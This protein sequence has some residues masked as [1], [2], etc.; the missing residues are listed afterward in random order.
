MIVL[1]CTAKLLD[2]LRCG[3]T[4][5]SAGSTTVLG[6]WYA[7]FVPTRPAQMVLLVS[8]PSRLPV[9]LPAREFSTLTTRIPDAVAGILEGLGMQRDMVERER[10][11]MRHIVVAPTARRSVLGTMNEFVSQLKWLRQSKPQLSIR[12]LSLELAQTPVGSLGYEHPAEAA[13][14]L[15]FPL[16][17]LKS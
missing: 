1:R 4:P 17:G 16:Q 6:D 13:K 9:L 11:A 5:T 7:T 14:R 12:E 8:E 3:S 2:R 15:L 10:E